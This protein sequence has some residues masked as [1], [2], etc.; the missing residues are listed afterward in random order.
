MIGS[1]SRG[2][3]R[4]VT[5]AAT[6]A[7][8]VLVVTGCSSGGGGGGTADEPVEITFWTWLPDIQTTVD[9]FEAANPDITVK[10]ENVG[11]GIDEYTKLQNAV[12]AGSGGPDVAHMTYDAIPAF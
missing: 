6:L 2:L 5:V 7:A 1:T 9:K 12:D 10:V 3:R 8:S 4:A 11:V